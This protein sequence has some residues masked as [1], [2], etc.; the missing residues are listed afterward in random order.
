MDEIRARH[1]TV[2]RFVM[3]LDPSSTNSS[4]RQWLERL[5]C[6]LRRFQA[7]ESKAA[8]FMRLSEK[9]ADFELSGRLSL[10]VRY[11]FRLNL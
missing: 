5:V 6:I 10:A 2:E 8:A 11:R 1:D 9:Q 3:V 4:N 7:F